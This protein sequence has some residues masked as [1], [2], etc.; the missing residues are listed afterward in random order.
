MHRLGTLL[1]MLSFV[2]AIAA[3]MIIPMGQTWT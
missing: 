1:V 2:V 3:M